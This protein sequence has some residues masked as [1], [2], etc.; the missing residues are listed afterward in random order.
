MSEKWIDGSR[1]SGAFLDARDHLLQDAAA[2]AKFGFNLAHAW[3]AAQQGILFHGTAVHL[4]P[5]VLRI[6]A[7]VPAASSGN[8]FSQR[9]MRVSET[10][11]R[12]AASHGC[13]SMCL[14][15]AEG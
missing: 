1:R 6:R 2:E 5:G 7:A 3:D 12:D 13:R 15:R 9:G 10:W 11:S 8:P 4:T 14:H